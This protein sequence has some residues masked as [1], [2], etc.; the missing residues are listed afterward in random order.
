[1]ADNKSMLA[2]FKEFILSGDLVAIAVAFVMAA[3]LG[4]LIQSF[5]KNIFNGILALFMP[6][7]TK[8]LDSA[9]IIKDKVRVGAF[10]SSI[11]AF[12]VLAF[13][14]FLI[15]KAYKNTQKAKA[16]EVAGPSDN[17]LLKEIL[18]ALKR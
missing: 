5:I 18:V 3:A 12:V 8:N 14:V 10:V 7:S 4:D 2:E 15:V 17:D 1:M 6:D 9:W 11:F 16:A 13:V